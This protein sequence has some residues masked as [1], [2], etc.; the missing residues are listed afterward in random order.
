MMVCIDLLHQGYKARTGPKKERKEAGE[1]TVSS[2]KAQH[3]PRTKGTQRK[4][5]SDRI[6]KNTTEILADHS[7]AGSS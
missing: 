5:N 2:N 3:A 4:M 7:R 6:E 1:I